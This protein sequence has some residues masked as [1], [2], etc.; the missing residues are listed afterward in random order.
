MS[1]TAGFV[2]IVNTRLEINALDG[3]ES[4]ALAHFS[5]PRPLPM[6]LESF[7]EHFLYQLSLPEEIVGYAFPIVEKFFYHISQYNIHKVVF[8]ALAL[9][10]KF[11]TDLSVTNSCLEKIGLL[12][13][14][15]LRKLELTI[16]EEIDWRIEYK[17]I[18]PVI[19]RLLEA[20]KIQDIQIDEIE[21]SEGFEDDETDFTEYGSNS[22]FSE[23]GAFFMN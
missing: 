13:A 18:E 15:E 12:K 22:S 9:T 20:G 1:L 3:H 17:N 23:L 10:Y 8:T 6:R 4:Q 2:S 19:E 21:D 5:L 7:I 11:F 14:G 16:L